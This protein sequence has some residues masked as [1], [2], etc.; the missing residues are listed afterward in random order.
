VAKRYQQIIDKDFKLRSQFPVYYDGQ[1]IPLTTPV[2][3]TVN[4]LSSL[5]EGGKQKGASTCKSS[6]KYAETGSISANERGYG[7]ILTE[8]TENDHLPKI[9]EVYS[10]NSLNSNAQ[11]PGL[12]TS[13][14]GRLSCKNEETFAR[15]SDM[16]NKQPSKS[17]LQDVNTCTHSSQMKP[18]LVSDNFID[19]TIGD[20]EEIKSC[21]D[22]D[23]ARP[24]GEGMCGR[25]VNAGDQ[26]EFD[27][28]ME[29]TGDKE[30]KNKKSNQHKR[31]GVFG[32][33]RKGKRKC[34]AQNQNQKNTSK[35]L[36]VGWDCN[37]CNSDSLIQGDQDKTQCSVLND[38]QNN[39]QGN[40]EQKL[41]DLNNDNDCGKEEKNS[42]V[43][44][45]E[46]KEHWNGNRINGGVHISSDMTYR[47]NKI[48]T[49]KA[50]L[51][52]QE[53]EL[54][55]LRTQKESNM[56]KVMSMEAPDQDVRQEKVESEAN[57]WSYEVHERQE[58]TKDD[59]VEVNLDDICQHVIKS[60]D[61]FNARQWESKTRK[62]E[63]FHTLYEENTGIIKQANERKSECNDVAYL[64]Q[65]RQE[66]FLFEI[67]L[68]RTE[69]T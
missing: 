41:N 63:G 11:E 21:N 56:A 12:K 49:L 16:S 61:I 4:T 26:S 30:R 54:V 38:Q 65:G 57:D 34:P 9:V 3:V 31:K 32:S 44:T 6:E 52:K 46:R 15:K 69:K 14:Q 51:A 2:K 22:D 19:L 20:E 68:R 59:H 25:D 37:G 43:K 35:S 24:G 17:L 36:N 47:E 28:P 33:G 23:I 48:T 55:R 58:A 8:K 53:E 40:G 45:E 29:D 60:F 10:L 18:Y 39:N 62:K 1:M 5:K 7:S 64:P 66:E 27:P 67:G 42:T 50:R 13:T